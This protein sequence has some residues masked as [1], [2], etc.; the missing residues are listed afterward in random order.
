MNK[1]VIQITRER[2]FTLIELI[3]VTIILG[4][5]AM[6]AVPRYMNSVESAE[7]AAEDDVI[8]SIND[9][10]ETHALD[11]LTSTGRAYWL[12]NPFDALKTKHELEF[13]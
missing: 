6:L 9:G 1:M 11:M 10:L 4:I 12:S 5:L 2:G 3:V 8:A 7:I 13:V